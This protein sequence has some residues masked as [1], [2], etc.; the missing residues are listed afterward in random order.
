MR[1]FPKRSAKVVAV[2]VTQGDTVEA[3]KPLVS[4]ASGELEHDINV[5][6][7]NIQMVRARL[8]RLTADDT[9]RENRVVSIGELAAFTEK[10]QGLTQ[11]REE[12]QIRAPI[13]GRIVELNPAL[14]PGRTVN[15]K[16]LIALVSGE[17]S[18]VARG[19][20]GESEIWRLGPGAAG[21]VIPES[22]ARATYNV[23]VREISPSG[24]PSLDIPDLA[25][26]YGGKIA[27]QPDVQH[28][29][30]PVDAQY[31]VTFAVENSGVRPEVRFRGV[32]H[33]KGA[34]ESFAAGLW[35]QTIK[36]LIR[37]GGA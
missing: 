23:A 27:V 37:E 33:I 5:V 28:R 18:F 34:A 10:L 26:T 12:L 32:A 1:V 17:T 11:E 16:E 14:E 2:H 24:A 31:A 3:G 15:S 4:L 21:K 9:D 22:I 8:A 36:V 6:N 13:T 30:V 19:F 25:S 35:R 29:L 7:L 20:I